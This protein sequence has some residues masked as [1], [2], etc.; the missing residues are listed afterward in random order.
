MEALAISNTYGV[1]FY[2]QQYVSE[3]DQYHLGMVL[4]KSLVQQNFTV[5][6]SPI[7]PSVYTISLG[8]VLPHSLR[9]IQCG[10]SEVLCILL[11]NGQFLLYET[12]SLLT[13]AFAKE[14]PT[15][16]DSTP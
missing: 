13:I 14:H 12:D 6:E 8:N 4:T 2:I 15:Q 10:T 7:V 5:K 1:L 16:E 3:E 11:E 9:T